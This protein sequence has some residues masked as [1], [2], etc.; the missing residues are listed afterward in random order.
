MC[1]EIH[2]KEF[3]SV[4]DVI[5]GASNSTGTGG[6]LSHEIKKKAELRI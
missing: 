2:C 4:A 6:F 5:F 1:D 3:H